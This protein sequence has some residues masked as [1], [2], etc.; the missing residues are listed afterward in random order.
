VLARLWF[1]L[2]ALGVMNATGIA[3]SDDA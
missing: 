2:A 3:R 1:T